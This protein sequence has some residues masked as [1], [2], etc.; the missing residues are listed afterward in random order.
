LINK[1][2]LI[3]M[4]G[5][6]LVLQPV[7]CGSSS[8]SS[9]SKSYSDGQCQSK[10]AM[11]SIPLREG[12]IIYGSG[13]NWGNHVGIITKNSTGTFF[14][15]EALMSEGVTSKRTPYCFEQSYSGVAL[16]R[17]KNYDAKLAA[18]A[19]K[20]A[21]S[22]QN[23]SYWLG[24]GDW[25]GS[26]EWYCSKL[27]WKAYE[28]AGLKLIA[29]NSACFDFDPSIL[30]AVWP[31]EIATSPDLYV[32]WS[33]GWV[34]KC[35]I[36]LY[37]GIR[38]TWT[39]IVPRN[40]YYNYALTDLLFYDASAGQAEM[41]ENGQPNGYL[42]K[43]KSYSGWLKTWTTIVPGF[44][45]SDAYTD[46]LFYDASQGIGTMYRNDKNGN[47]IKM[48]DFS[49]WLKTW[50]TIVPGFFDSDTYTDLLFY[51][52][53]QGIG[54]MYRNDKKGNLIKMQDFSGWRKTWTT[55]VPGYFDS[56]TYTDLLF[57]DAS[58]GIGTMYRNDKKGNLI[59]MQDFSDWRKT[60]TT[61]VPG[62]F[63]GDSYTDLLFYDASAG[64]IEIYI[65]DKYG[66]LLPPTYPY[67]PNG[68]LSSRY[69]TN[70]EGYYW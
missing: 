67:R 5:F 29:K 6:C 14:V 11:N 57:Y 66:G 68:E 39:T 12:D 45:D 17:L 28:N 15:T 30:E 63:N 10:S 69:W 41:Y 42:N 37:S 47:L 59:K 48:H 54:T 22:K 4:V 31:D 13:S 3:L 65:N 44:F 52:A 58:Q 43:V 25:T 24:V 34:P 23:L 8:S 70:S 33:K 40:S 50:T 49:G 2:V 64:Q 56:D 32:V 26:N 61:I 55:I 35:A 19:C 1:L 21:Q 27:V 53:S 7:D 36:G 46:L 38:S 62:D 20:F 9:S 18:D 60:W 51:D 16:L